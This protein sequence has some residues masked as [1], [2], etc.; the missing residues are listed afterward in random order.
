MAAAAAVAV[1]AFF[2]AFVFTAATFVI[3]IMVVPVTTTASAAVPLDFAHWVGVEKM[4]DF[5]ENRSIFHHLF[6]Q[7]FVLLGNRLKEGGGIAQE[8]STEFIVFRHI[9]LS[10]RRL[11]VFVY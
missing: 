7:S 10:F 4:R 3:V 8:L 9:R 11:D 1:T 2:L 6:A 5:F